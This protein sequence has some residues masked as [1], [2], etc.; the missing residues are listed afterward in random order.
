MRAFLWWCLSP[1]SSLVPCVIGA[2]RAPDYLK[3]TFLGLREAQKKARTCDFEA[4]PRRPTEGAAKRRGA[5]PGS[6]DRRAV[7]VAEPAFAQNF[8]FSRFPLRSAQFVYWGLH[9]EARQPRLRETE[10]L[11]SARVAP[12]LDLR[13][14]SRGPAGASAMSVAVAAHERGADSARQ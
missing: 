9:L 4:D 1:L 14:C 12:L 8:H 13:T 7:P 2:R 5:S 3:Y 6:R 11:E 10:P